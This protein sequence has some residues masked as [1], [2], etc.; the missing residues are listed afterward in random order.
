MGE[1][2]EFIEGTGLVE[3]AGWHFEKDECD[4]YLHEP[5]QIAAQIWREK[6]SVIRQQQSK[7]EQL[8][9]EKQQALQEFSGLSRFADEDCIEDFE[10]LKGAVLSACAR[11]EKALRGE[12]E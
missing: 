2:E 4:E 12:C 3:F 10:F 6:E 11:I 1:F 8:E 7:I 5:T 9:K